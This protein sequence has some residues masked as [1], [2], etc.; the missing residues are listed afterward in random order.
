[1]A[2][3]RAELQKLLLDASPLHLHRCGQEAAAAERP[4]SACAA[5]SARVR[6]PKKRV[7][8]W[9]LKFAFLQ[10]P[11]RRAFTLRIT[12]CGER[13]EFSI[14]SSVYS[15][16]LQSTSEAS[17]VPHP[18][19]FLAVGKSTLAMGVHT[20]SWRLAWVLGCSW[21]RRLSSRCLTTTS[22]QI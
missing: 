6:L 3:D 7:P 20:G 11:R 18:A 15:Q 19:R 4:A 9:V 5:A 14:K 22:F 16:V 1:M 2:V 8:L 12:L 13:R 21:S 10:N 17:I